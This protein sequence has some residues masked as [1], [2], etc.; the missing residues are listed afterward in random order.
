MKL[1]KA[2]GVA[3]KDLTRITRLLRRYCGAT[4]EGLEAVLCPLLVPI[5]ALDKKIFKLE[6][7]T[8][9]R[10]SFTV[11]ITP[12]NQSVLQIGRTGKFVPGG[13]G[14]GAAWLEVAKGRIIKLDEANGIALGEIYT[15]GKRTDLEAALKKLTK[16]DLL[17]IDQ[18]GAAAKVLSGLA[19]YELC[20]LAQ[21]R[22]YRVRRMPEDMARHLGCYAN[23]DFE[24]E[25]GG[26]VQKVEV[27]SLWGTNTQYARLIHS[28]T[29]APKGEEEDWTD[30]QRKNYYPTSSCKFGTQDVF[31][32]SL[33]LRTGNIK[34]FAFARSVPKDEKSFGLPRA[35]G[36]PD[37]LNQNP[38]CRIG[39]GTWFATIDEVW[40][41]DREALAEGKSNLKDSSLVPPLK[42]VLNKDAKG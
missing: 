3:S 32:V 37:H 27:K 22:G 8:H 29:T 25:K 40:N 34:D 15:G 18:Y 36:Y 7:Q 20:A 9:Y 2:A 30:E 13:Y 39:D 28:T 5:H 41:L 42:K 14:E 31:A 38:T 12:E 17:E 23:Y 4:P 16:D 26:R 19:E 21:A 35:T 10:A 11:R 1:E 6:K 24:F 33:F